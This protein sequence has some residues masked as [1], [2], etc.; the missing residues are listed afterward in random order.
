MPHEQSRRA[1]AIM[2]RSPLESAHSASAVTRTADPDRARRLRALAVLAV[3]AVLVSA[4]SATESSGGASGGYPDR[5]ITMVVPFSAGGPTDTVTRLIAEP[6]S[7]KLG[8]QIVVQNV[9]GAGGTLGAGQV[10]RA[11]PDGYTVL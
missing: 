6:M 10:A 1:F 11:T 3:G 2:P 5:E 4:C 8:Q 7:A 9:E